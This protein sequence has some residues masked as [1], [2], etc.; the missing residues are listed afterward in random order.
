MR[1]RAAIYRV[2]SAGRGDGRDHIFKIVEILR[3]VATERAAARAATMSSRSGWTMSSGCKSRQRVAASLRH[4]SRLRHAFGAAAPAAAI[5]MDEVEMQQDDAES[6]ATATAAGATI[7]ATAAKKAATADED[8]LALQARMKQMLILEMAESK[9]L[10]KAA[11]N[12]LLNGAESER[13]ARVRAQLKAGKKRLQ[14][15]E[16]EQQQQQDDDDCVFEIEKADITDKDKKR[17][18]R[19]RGGKRGCKHDKRLKMDEN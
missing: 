13:T 7:V 4:L 19:P 8:P 2:G 18:R 16:E 14:E 9:R 5:A 10:S 1:R 12:S 6:S 17:S 15:F 3:G 11:E